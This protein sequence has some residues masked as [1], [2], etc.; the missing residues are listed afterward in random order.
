VAIDVDLDQPV[1]LAVEVGVHVCP[2][3][4]RMFRAQPPLLRPR[5]VYT[6]RVVQ[7]AVEAVYHDGLAM[8]GVPDHL[9]RDFWIKPDQKMV[10]L[11]C[12][13]YAAEIDFAVD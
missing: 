5:A 11:W 9:A 13:A 6:Q 8:R 12:R 1:V 10:R 4:S 7:K 3:C 2:V